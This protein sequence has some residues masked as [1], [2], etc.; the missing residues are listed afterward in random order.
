[1]TLREL[2]AAIALRVEKWPAWK[3]AAA[4]KGLLT[5]E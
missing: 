1:M 5:D 4:R 2:A 3:R